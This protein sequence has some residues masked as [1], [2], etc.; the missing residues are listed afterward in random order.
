MY[1][2]EVKW[3]TE[4]KTIHTWSSFLKPFS[5]GQEG[6]MNPCRI[7]SRSDLPESTAVGTRTWLFLMEVTWGHLMLRD[8]WNLINKTNETKTDL[9]GF[10]SAFINPWLVRSTI[11]AFQ[12]WVFHQQ[13]LNENT[14]KFK[15][16]SY[17]SCIVTVVSTRIRLCLMEVD[18]H[19]RVNRCLEPGEHK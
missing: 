8:V 4:C 11:T 7:N 5:L 13:G 18:C 17:L 16:T 9:F 19:L 6:V 10:R 2:G 14:M 15:W 3:L 1:V 12:F